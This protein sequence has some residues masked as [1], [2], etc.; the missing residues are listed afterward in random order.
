VLRQRAALIG[1][2]LGSA[3]GTAGA[4]AWSAEDA[5]FSEIAEKVLAA[6]GRGRTR[7]I[8]LIVTAGRS[9]DGSID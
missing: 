7:S 1:R 3:A 6:F 5:E 9:V 4:S 8:F 2:H